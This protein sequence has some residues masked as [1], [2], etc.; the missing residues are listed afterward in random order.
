MQQ[1][2]IAHY[3]QLVLGARGVGTA[4]VTVHDIGLA[5]PASASALV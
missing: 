4:L 2:P 5:S 3:M 1:P